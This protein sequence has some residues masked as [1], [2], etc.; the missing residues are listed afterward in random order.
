MRIRLPLK[1][2]TI[3]VLTV[4]FVGCKAY[5]ETMAKASQNKI[6]L[7]SKSFATAREP[8]YQFYDL[9]KGMRTVVMPTEPHASLDENVYPM[10]NSDIFK[11]PVANYIKSMG[12]KELNSEKDY[13]L[14]ITQNKVDVNTWN[15]KIDVVLGIRMTDVSGKEVYSQEIA[16]SL[17]NMLNLV[18]GLSDCYTKALEQV[19][20]SEIATILRN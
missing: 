15:G 1:I 19:N 10:S 16:T 8:Q 14:T 9:A 20:W 7:L 3:A 2:L 4:A 18:R 13:S 6:E 11:E 12:F 5:K 17:V